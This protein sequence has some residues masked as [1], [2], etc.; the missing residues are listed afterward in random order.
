M[1]ATDM[2]AR[3]VTLVFRSITVS[4]HKVEDEFHS[5][6]LSDPIKPV[7]INEGSLTKARA[8]GEAHTRFKTRAHSP[9]I[10]PFGL[11]QVLF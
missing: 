6:L 2:Q 10:S 7:F 4:G 3:I 11:P 1:F 5:S 8:I 9:P